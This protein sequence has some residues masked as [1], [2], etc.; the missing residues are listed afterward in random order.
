[1]PPEG[2]RVPLGRPVAT[3]A[4]TS[5]T[6]S[7]RR[8]RSA[9]RARS[10]SPGVC[11]GRGYVNDPERTVPRSSPI[12]TATGERLYRSGDRG[13]WRP[14][15]KLEFLGRRDGQV[16]VAGHRIEIGEVESALARAPAWAR[17]RS[18]SRAGPTAPGGW[19]A[20]TP[21]LGRLETA[22]LRG[23]LAESLPRYMVP[24]TLH[25]RRELPLTANGKVDRKAL[26]SAEPPDDRGADIRRDLRRRGPGD[27]RGARARDRRRRRARVPARRAKATRSARPPTRCAF[28]DRPSARINALP[29]SLG[30]D[31]RA[32]GLKWISSFPENVGGRESRG[33]RRS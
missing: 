25:W 11:V 27:A 29:A 18:W 26:R 12:P 32:H 22:A 2:E 4:Y 21:A 15:G 17:L 7:S 6:S 19:S 8:S 3:P 33:R 14:D 20:S 10:S 13:R 30:G 9:R 5:S 31:V 1:M 16:K 24:S 28:P 23:R